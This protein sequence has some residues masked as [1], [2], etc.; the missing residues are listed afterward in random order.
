MNFDKKRHDILKANKGSR[1]SYDPKNDE[2]VITF[3]GKE[4]FSIPGDCEF[5]GDHI[6][7][8]NSDKVICRVKRD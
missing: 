6:Y 8:E 3:M 1:L 2:F 5:C 4:G 7:K